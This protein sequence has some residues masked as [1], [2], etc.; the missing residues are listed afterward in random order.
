MKQTNLLFYSQIDLPY[1]I[2]SPTTDLVCCGY[3]IICLSRQNG[4][5]EN[6][7]E[8]NT[9]SVSYFLINCANFK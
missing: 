9:S 7:Y 5:R 6:I 8:A 3:K 1:F 2:S 4:G